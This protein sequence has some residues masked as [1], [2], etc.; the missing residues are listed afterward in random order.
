MRLI[1]RQTTNNRIITGKGYKYDPSNDTS[2]IEANALV[3]P[4]GNTSSKPLNPINGSVRYNNEINE[5]EFYVNNDWQVVRYKSPGLISQQVVGTGNDVDTIFGPLLSSDLAYPSPVSANNILV[6]VENIFQISP[7]NFTME[8]NP[9]STGTG[10]EIGVFYLVNNN[11]YVIT[12]LGNTDWS[13]IGAGQSAQV[14]DVFTADLSLDVALTKTLD[15]PNDYN[16]PSSADDF[17][18]YSVAINNNGNQSLILV[19]AHQEDD[20]LGDQAGKAYIFNLDGTLLYT[21]QNPQAFGGTTEDL[22]GFSV[23]ISNAY[24]A[25]GAHQEDDASGV[26]DN[27]GKVFVYDLAAVNTTVPTYTFDNQNL[28]TTDTTDWYGYS[29]GVSDTHLVVGAPREDTVALINN[30]AVYLYEFATM[31]GAPYTSIRL[32]NPETNGLYFGS[33]V[34]ISDNYVIVGT[35][36]LEGVVYQNKV[37][38]YNLS[39]NL[40]YTLENPNQTTSDDGFGYSV[41]ISNTYAIV[42]SFREDSDINTDNGV[43]YIYKLLDTDPTSP[44]TLSPEVYPGSD[45]YGGIVNPNAFADASNDLFGFKVSISDVYAAISAHVEDGPGVTNSGIVYVYDLLT[46]EKI[47]DVLNPNAYG[48]AQ[49]DQFGSAVSLSN[50]HL[51]V[52]AYQEDDSTGDSSGK[53]YVYSIDGKAAGTGLVRKEGQY[54]EF[55]SYVPNNKPI[56]VYHNF[57]K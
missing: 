48:L 3:V 22:F 54:L 46:G 8:L 15:N 18:A 25:V 9:S 45:A 28:A 5:F 39:G 34:A 57:D 4:I 44:T 26:G 52:G 12:N 19:G 31:G 55:T 41:D 30:G 20:A 49:S 50:N 42:G 27:S 1:K 17:F 14:G 56:T 40:L 51:I 38:I 6:F 21:L 35:H 10:S 47:E 13:K 37:Y 16:S 23:D 43:A 36:P 29:V 7:Q 11:N 53:A 2:T 33:T 24:A 32:N